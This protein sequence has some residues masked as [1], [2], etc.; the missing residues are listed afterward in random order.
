M[1]EREIAGQE[2]VRE[3]ASVPASVGE[4]RGIVRCVG[5][6]LPERML[7]DA[8]LL[9]SELM[10]NAVRHGGGAIRLRVRRHEPGSPGPSVLT[11]LVYDAGSVLPVATPTRV[12][13]ESASGR[14]LRM[15]DELSREWGVEVDRA[16]GKTVWFELASAEPDR[17]REGQE[18][19]ERGSASAWS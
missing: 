15:V 10:S 19:H 3:L 5:A 13:P 18:K 9:V 4:A 1:T 16:G 6:G 8:E 7:D 2:T 17:P 12:G 14:G 11:V